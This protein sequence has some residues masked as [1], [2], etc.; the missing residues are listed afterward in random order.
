MNKRGFV[1]LFVTPEKNPKLNC[2]SD[3]NGIVIVFQVK[4]PFQQSESH[5]NKQANINKYM[6]GKLLSIW[7]DFLLHIVFVHCISEYTQIREES[8][9]EK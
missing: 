8:W 7:Y 1:F 6:N 9:I 3:K 2:R 4:F 5:T